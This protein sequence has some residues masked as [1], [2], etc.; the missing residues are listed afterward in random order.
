MSEETTLLTDEEI[1][2][3]LDES[4]DTSLSTTEGASS[5]RGEDEDLSYHLRTIGV[6]DEQ[7]PDLTNATPEV[8]ELVKSLARKTDE[9]I[10]G[11]Q[12]GFSKLSD[13][14]RQDAAN[15]QQLK[16]DPKFVELYS[17]YRSGQI[18]P[19]VEEELD[20]SKL[21]EDPMERF[22]ILSKRAAEKALDPKLTAIESRV[23]QVVQAIGSLMWDNFVVSHP[24]AESG[25]NEIYGMI[26]NGMSLTNAYKAW[27]GMNVD[28]SAIEEKVLKRVRERQNEKKKAAMIP[29][30]K[31]IAGS[32][33][34]KGALPSE[35]AEIEK[36]QGRR[37]A[38]FHALGKHSHLLD[39]I[40]ED[41]DMF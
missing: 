16:N 26:G 11:M 24:D 33:P 41:L 31:H 9:R 29:M 7:I 1:D 6:T 37:A 40:K 15:Y 19:V 4:P 27:K 21:P 36:T 30:N 8:K 13:E 32:T 17:N 10:R 22:N 2:A 34:T 28:E 3:I 23:N 35:L 14:V 25:K 18:P 20:L 5:G 12:S 38:F 39:S